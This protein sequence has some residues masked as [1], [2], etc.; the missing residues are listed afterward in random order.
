MPGIRTSSSAKAIGWAL[1]AYADT[2]PEAVKAFVASR[3]LSPLS[4]RESA[5]SSS[6]SGDRRS[7]V[8]AVGLL[9]TLVEGAGPAMLRPVAAVLPGPVA[10]VLLAM[11]FVHAHFAAWWLA[12]FSE[13]NTCWKCPAQCR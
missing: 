6:R 2:D 4:M 3:T 12:P 10:T 5:G 1:R 13:L 9:R 7:S 11:A 8:P